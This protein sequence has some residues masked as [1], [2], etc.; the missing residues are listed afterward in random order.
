[1]R[2]FRHTTL[3]RNAT[4]DAGINYITASTIPATYTATNLKFQ[5]SDCAGYTE[6]TQLF[7]EYKINKIIVR[8]TPKYTEAD[9]TLGQVTASSGSLPR[10]FTAIDTDGRFSSSTFSALCEYGNMRPQVANRDIVVSFKPVAFTPLQTSAAGNS[11][12][13]KPVTG[14]ISTYAPGV[15][16][17]GLI[18]ASVTAS[19]QTG[20][21]PSTPFEWETLVTYDVSFRKTL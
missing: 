15:D 8:F 4:D 12:F 16:F 2:I 5:L 1:M 14:W 11:S 18:F 9:A 21:N 17:Y 7:D 10:V 19:T 13:T 6:L 3:V 20:T